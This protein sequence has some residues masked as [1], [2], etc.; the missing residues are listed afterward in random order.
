MRRQDY[1]IVITVSFAMDDYDHEPTTKDALDHLDAI[2]LDDKIDECKTC[3]WSIHAR[4][5]ES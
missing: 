3:C 1:D 2:I 5:E 4:Q